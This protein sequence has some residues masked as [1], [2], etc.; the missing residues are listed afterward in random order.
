MLFWKPGRNSSNVWTRRLLRT[1]GIL[2]GIYLIG[3]AGLELVRLQLAKDPW[4]EDARAAR[5][6]AQSAGKQRS[7]WFGPAGY[8]PADFKE[9][10]QR[11][12]LG[13]KKA[14]I[15][16]ARVE[17]TKQVYSE[18]KHKNRERARDILAQL[19]NENEPKFASGIT[20]HVTSDPEWEILEPW[21]QLQDETDI[22]VRL[23]IHSRGVVE[24]DS[25]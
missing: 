6:K 9:W 16:G 18:I 8:Q 23:V 13:L 25:A 21:E 11:V 2:S 5:L 4:A 7:W 1:G 12:E 22:L 24:E 17:A 10:R 19:Q 15:V 20:E 14:D 3:F